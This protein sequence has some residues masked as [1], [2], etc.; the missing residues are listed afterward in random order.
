MISSRTLNSKSRDFQT[1]SLNPEGKGDPQIFQQIGHWFLGIAP[2][3][4]IMGG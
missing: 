4:K 3:M 1:K 2:M